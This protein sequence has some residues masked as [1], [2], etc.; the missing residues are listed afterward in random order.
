MTANHISST[1]ATWD[2]TN[3]TTSGTT[4]T[5][6]G[7]EPQIISASAYTLPALDDDWAIRNARM[8]LRRDERAAIVQA[9][10]GEPRSGFSCS[11]IGYDAIINHKSPGSRQRKARKAKR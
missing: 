5:Y 11:R 2:A 4:A 7:N 6:T 3:T 1:T 10:K 8:Q 9:D